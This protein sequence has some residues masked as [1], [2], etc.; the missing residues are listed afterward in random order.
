M[1]EFPDGGVA[2]HPSNPRLDYA[3]DHVRFAALD[4][5]RLM[6]ADLCNAVTNPADIS[7]IH[8]RDLLLRRPQEI[9]VIMEEKRTPIPD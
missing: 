6:G 9:Y 7:T 8:R 4:S 3:T 1:E 2:R 5:G